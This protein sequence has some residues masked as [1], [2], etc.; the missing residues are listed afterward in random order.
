MK[1]GKL[2]NEILKNE[3]LSK[4]NI[5]NRDVLVG[6]GIGEDCSIIDFGEEKCVITTDPITGATSEIGALS[7]HISCNDIASAGVRPIGVMV[8]ILA[9][10]DSTVEDIKKV[11]DDIVRSCSELSVQVLGGHTEVTDA[12]NKMIVSITAIGKGKEV[13]TTSGAKIGDDIVVTGY[14]GLEGTVII[15]SDR[16]AV[17]SKHFTLD[18][19]TNMKDMMESISV[20]ETG[21][22]AAKFKVNSMH[23][24]TEGGI[25][26]AIYEV[27]EA[28]GL[29]VKIYEDIIPIKE[30]TKKV[31]KIFNLDPYRLI[32]SGSMI[33]TTD[34]G[35]ELCTYLKSHGIN[36]AVVG[37]ITN[38]ENILVKNGVSTVLYG[39]EVDE[40]YKI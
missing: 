24:A 13:V 30:E 40:I 29:T 33:I 17:L 7:V 1:I 31:S 35:E 6:P 11:M 27:G 4:I 10:V 9:P 21:I 3:I 15:A 39:P 38:E 18:E 37:K 32:S 20:V 2:P 16:E 12:V 25:L 28:S 5:D 14:A 8:T 22:L 34:R 23:D 26:G 36:S 19:I